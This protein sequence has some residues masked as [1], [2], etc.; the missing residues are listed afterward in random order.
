MISF[1]T[2]GSMITHLIGILIITMTTIKVEYFCFVY[3]VSSLFACVATFVYGK[4]QISI[5]RKR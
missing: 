2:M 4:R 5:E 3:A 1:I